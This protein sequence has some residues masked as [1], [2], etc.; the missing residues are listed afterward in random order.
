MADTKAP[1][2]LDEALRPG[3]LYYT[4]NGTAHDANGNVLEGAPKR[5]DNTNPD[6]QPF[7]KFASGVG[8]S[9]APA[10]MDMRTLGM[11]IAQGLK[12][13]AEGAVDEPKA[14]DA[15]AQRDELASAAADAKVKPDTP[16]VQT[17]ANPELTPGGEAAAAAAVSGNAPTIAPAG[18]SS[19]ES[20]SS[21][22][23]L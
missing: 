3:G 18:S 10:G 12:L 23:K 15:V 5:P 20:G 6:D 9:G 13:G 2:R 16:P 1:R 7:A 22:E 8:A 21:D 14:A 11:A 19:S 17:R 4:A